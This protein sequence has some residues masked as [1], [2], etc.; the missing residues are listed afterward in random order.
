MGRAEGVE[1]SAS[2]ARDDGLHGCGADVAGVPQSG[3]QGP[4]GGYGAVT[5]TPGMGTQ[6]PETGT[7]AVF[8]SGARSS[9]RKPRY[10]LIPFVALERVAQRYTEGAET[11]GE[12]NYQRGAK[13]RRYREDRLN[14]AIEHLWRYASGDRSE[15]HLAAAAWGCLTLMWFES[16]QE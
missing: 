12:D 15:D 4:S 6:I 5:L 7:T 13:D 14:H 2:S 1:G 11:H 3:T 16:V 10:A 9:E 8:A